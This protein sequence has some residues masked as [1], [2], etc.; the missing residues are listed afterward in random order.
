MRGAC[1]L[2][3]H[4]DAARV[5]AERERELARDELLA[6]GVAAGV[7]YAYDGPPM[8]APVADVVRRI[9]ELTEASRERDALRARIAEA[10]RGT[11]EILIRD[12]RGVSIGCDATVS[13]DLC[14]TRVA[15]VALAE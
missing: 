2:I 9:D 1:E 5:E 15:I 6:I 13:D 7:Y 3:E 12:E 10:P 4:L 8:P 14:G 11:I